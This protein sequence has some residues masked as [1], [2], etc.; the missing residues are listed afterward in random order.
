MLYVIAYHWSAERFI[1][2]TADEWEL[3]KFSVSQSYSRLSEQESPGLHLNLLSAKLATTRTGGESNH[4]S[5]SI[6]NLQIA[7]L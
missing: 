1:Y 6:Y 2:I 7:T 5:G 4:R 3:G